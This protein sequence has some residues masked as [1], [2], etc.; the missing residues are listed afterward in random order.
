MEA[1]SL[2]REENRR[3]RCSCYPE[4]HRQPALLISRVGNSKLKEGKSCATNKTHKAPA[5]SSLQLVSEVFV[6]LRSEGCRGNNNFNT[7]ELKDFRFAST[8]ISASCC[9]PEH[10]KLF[11]HQRPSHSAKPVKESLKKMLEN[12]TCGGKLERFFNEKRHKAAQRA[13]E[14]SC[15]TSLVPIQTEAIAQGFLTRLH[16]LS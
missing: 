7:L 14:E 11:S 9:H 12:V 4:L 6:P 8:P 10:I 1:T 2:E 15:W 5:P 16:C 13:R 3:G